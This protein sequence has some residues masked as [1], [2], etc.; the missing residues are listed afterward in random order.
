LAR[1]L[2]RHGHPP[3]EITRP[4]RAGA[5]RM[6]GKNDAVDAEHA[7]RAVLAGIAT[8]E[9]K[10]ADGPCLPTPPAPNHSG[11]RAAGRFRRVDRLDDL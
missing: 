1:F 10:V 11:G 9:A 2:R 5:R 3:I 7:A 6:S 8:V 4:P